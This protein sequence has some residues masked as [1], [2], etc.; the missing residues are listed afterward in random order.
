MNIESNSLKKLVENLRPLTEEE[1]SV[2]SGGNPDESDEF[3][4]VSAPPPP[5]SPSPPPDLSQFLVEV[6]NIRRP[7]RRR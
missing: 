1:I 3:I 2:V 4:V 5:P 7:N 6:P